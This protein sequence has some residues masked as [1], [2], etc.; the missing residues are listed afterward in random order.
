MSDSEVAWCKRYS[1]GDGLRNKFRAGYSTSFG[2][3]PLCR[4]SWFSIHSTSHLWNHSSSRW[5]HMPWTETSNRPMCACL[6]RKKAVKS[7]EP[8]TKI[9]E[10]NIYAKVPHIGDRRKPIHAVGNK[11]LSS[12]WTIRS[13]M[14]VSPDTRRY[15]PIRNATFPC[16]ELTIYRR[17]PCSR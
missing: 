17:T 14:I 15:H 7:L 16:G 12:R 8:C 6:E 1:K 13:L 2:I 3:P 10:T 4:S 9:K 11:T 5:F